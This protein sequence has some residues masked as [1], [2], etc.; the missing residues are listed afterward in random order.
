LAVKGE[1]KNF[2]INTGPDPE[3]EDNIEFLSLGVLVD[4]LAY[5]C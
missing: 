4:L 3:N 5:S 2:K 1:L